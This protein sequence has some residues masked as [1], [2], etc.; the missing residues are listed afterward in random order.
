MASKDMWEAAYHDIMKHVYGVKP[1]HM[2]LPYKIK[3]VFTSEQANEIENQYKG[4][5]LVEIPS[6]IVF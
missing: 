4:R 5:K 3:V 6:A 1:Q 2:N